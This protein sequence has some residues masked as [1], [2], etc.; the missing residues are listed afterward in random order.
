[1]IPIQLELDG[2][3]SEFTAEMTG[4]ELDLRNHVIPLEWRTNPRLGQDID[5]VRRQ[6]SG[7]RV[8]LRVRQVDR[9]SDVDRD[10]RSGQRSTVGVRRL[11]FSRSGSELHH[12]D[13]HAR[14]SRRD[15][16]AGGLAAVVAVGAAIQRRPR[17]ADGAS[18]VETEA[19]RRFSC[20]PNR[21]PRPSSP[22]YVGR[23]GR[24]KRMSRSPLGL[25]TKTC[26]RTLAAEHRCQSV[27]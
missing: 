18:V 22:G 4:T 17:T 7:Q 26:W 21:Q 15:V 19:D 25:A 6:P 23:L 11:G 8:L 24:R 20:H 2:A 10:G 16:D 13:H 1:M 5:S 3:R 14:A 12:D 27:N 9:S